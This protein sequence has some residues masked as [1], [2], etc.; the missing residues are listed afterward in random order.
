MYDICAYIYTTKDRLMECMVS[1]YSFLEK[2]VWFKGEVIISSD[3]DIFDLEWK[4]RMSGLYERLYFIENETIETLLEN[5]NYN[6]IIVL[7]NNILFV[8]SVYDEI[9]NCG[10]V[11]DIN[12][13]SNEVKIS[14]E[15]VDENNFKD[16]KIITFNDGVN[17]NDM[18]VKVIIDEYVSEILYT[19]PFYRFNTFET[20][21]KFPKSLNDRFKYVICVCAR[22][23]NKYIIEWINHYL[24]LGFD[25]I[26]ICD[27]NSVGDNSLYETIKS[28]VLNGNVE[29]FDCQKLTCFQVQFYTMFCT[30]GNYEWCGYFDCDEF[31]ELPSHFNVKH[32][33]DT[34][35]DELCVSFHW[36]IYGGNGL[37]KSEDKTLEERFKYPTSPIS[38][39]TENCFIK[40]IVRGN[41]LFNKGCWFNG[42]HIP[43]TSPMY[44]HNIG[45]HFRT[46]SDRH[47]YF[48][49]KYKDGYIKHYYTKSFEE[50]I[51]KS[52][53]GWPDGTDKL[54]IANYFICENWCELPLDKMK[55]GLFSTIKTEEECI[56]MYEEFLKENNVINVTNESHN[57]Y[58]LIIG[59]YNV[60]S[61]CT[62]YVFI[63]SGDHID[64]TV[65]NM[66]LEYGIKTGN[67]VVW[68]ETLE[69]KIA[70]GEKYSKYNDLFYNVE[71]K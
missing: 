49:P 61:I 59:M 54:N 36:M 1:V 23:E 44:E 7:N 56:D 15:D 9:I 17:V 41:G 11:I 45:G 35:K 39:Y 47:C 22:N 16:K 38:L 37:L 8:G 50:W 18:F 65:F 29:I 25:K 10:K 2:N 26:F 21:E 6:N 46:N 12:D 52:G 64:D 20:S 4:N 68:G 55:Y 34:K 51:N 24:G 33:L 3:G 30:E 66:I 5:Y 71:F 58:G 48:P 28:Y 62:D 57:I 70:I 60:M 14:A 19:G 42:S 53:R 40:S 63:L 43:M 32:Y 27:N 67:K 13:I 69:D 31:L